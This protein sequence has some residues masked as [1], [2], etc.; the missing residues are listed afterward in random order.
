HGELQLG[1]SASRASGDRHACAATL[2]VTGRVQGDSPKAEFHKSQGDTVSYGLLE[3]MVQFILR[4]F[5][6]SPTGM[7]PHAYLT[8]PFAEQE[9]FGLFNSLEPAG[10]NQLTARDARRQTGGRRFVPVRQ[11]Q[12]PSGCPDSVLAEAGLE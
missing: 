12:K 8:K 3:Q 6:T 1:F 2:P 7:I 5:D 9:C 10:C 4:H 11:P